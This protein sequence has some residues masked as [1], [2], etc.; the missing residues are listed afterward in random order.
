MKLTHVD[1]SGRAKMVDVSHKDV[2]RR[3][4]RA[5]GR[6]L[7]APQ[8]IT[9]IRDNLVK[10]GDVLTVAEVAGTMAA[11]RTG[12]L[13]PLCH[14]LGIDHIGV[15]CTLADD[16]VN[17]TSEAVCT[18]KTGI[19]MEAITAVTIA[20]VTIYDMCK[21]IDKNM[22]ITDVELVEKRKEVM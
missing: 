16:G 4:A 11:K 15:T 20:A 2:V 6:I 13:I 12:E 3:T 21:A 7:L 5:R 14:P 8:T 18:G 22:R 17:I 19:E 1:D 9:A 10:K